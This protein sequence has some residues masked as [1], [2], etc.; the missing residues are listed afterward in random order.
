MTYA[1]AATAKVQLEIKQHC[2]S[3]SCH[4]HKLI[5]PYRRASTKPPNNDMKFKK[6]ISSGQN[7]VLYSVHTFNL[8]SSITSVRKRAELRGCTATRV[9][10]LLTITWC[11]S[12]GVDSHHLIQRTKVC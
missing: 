10:E 1:A 8:I 3:F 11:N 5:V 9:K 7:S 12:V 4:I 6:C 2:M